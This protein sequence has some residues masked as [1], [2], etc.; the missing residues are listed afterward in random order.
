[1]EF[2]NTKQCSKCG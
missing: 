2:S 1:M